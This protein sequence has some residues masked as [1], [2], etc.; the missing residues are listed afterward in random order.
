VPSSRGADTISKHARRNPR[1]RISSLTALLDKLPKRA[2]DGFGDESNQRHIIAL[3]S[4]C[5][6]IGGVAEDASAWRLKGL[7]DDFRTP[8]AIR[9]MALRVF[10]G[11]V[12]PEARSISTFIS[13]LGKDDVRLNEAVYAATASFIAQCRRRVEYVRLIYAELSA[14]KRRVRQ[15]RL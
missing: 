3:L 12:Q 4:V 13:F 11:I 2:Q 6:S 9:R 15:G 5:E 7:A 8:L 1:I 14:L 10:G